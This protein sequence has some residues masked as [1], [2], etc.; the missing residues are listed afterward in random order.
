[1]AKILIADDS[2]VHIQLLTGWLQDRGFDVVA[3]LDAV[4]AWMKGLRSQPDLIILDIN[5]PG[6][7]G[8]EVLKR[9]KTSTKT[10][11]I[12]VLVVSGSGGSEMRDLVKRLGAADLFEKPLD[13]AQFCAA[14]AGLIV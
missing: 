2:R 13:C 14:V 12:P 3:A 4:Q 10:R 9:L 1:M 11:H 6:G 5:M 8:L 7:S